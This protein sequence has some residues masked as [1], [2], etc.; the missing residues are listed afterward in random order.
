MERF[1]LSRPARLAVFAS[2]Q[3]TNL[4]SILD[5]FPAGHQLASVQLVMSNNPDA[6]ALRRA[7]RQGIRTHHFPFP[8]RK[9]D[10]HGDK[11]AAFEAEAE[12][13]LQD[14]SIDLICLAGFM[15]L[16]SAEF[17]GRWSGRILNIHPSLLP[18]FPGLHP[19]KQALEAG[20]SESGCSVHFVDAGVDTGPVILQRR[21]LVLSADTVATLA[22]RI[23]QEEHQAYPEAIRRVLL[24]E[25]ALEPNEV[26]S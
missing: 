13:L 24:A 1:P 26:H 17:N 20:V 10:P 5:A 25:A 12:G 15:R 3:G 14:G 6:G 7:E 23:L 9:F 16:F 22:A 19:H 21:V 18:R 4:Q 2:G 11:C 8:S